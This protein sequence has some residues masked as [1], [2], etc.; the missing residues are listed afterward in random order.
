MK[1]NKGEWSEAYAFVKLI[2]EGEVHASDK[3]LNKIPD[4]LYPILKVYKDEIKRYYENNN[5]KGIIN[6][7][8]YDNNLISSLKS[9]KFISVA[10]DSLELINKSKGSSFEIPIME[11]FLKELGIINFKGSSKKK[12]D[13]KMEIFDN[14][15]EKSDILTFSI[16]SEIGNKP[17]LLNASKLTNFTYKVEGMSDG[18]FNYLNSI[19]KETDKKWI[20]TRF[21]K[22]FD[23]YKNK[24][25]KISLV[26]EKNNIFYQNL[27]LID[28]KL[29]NMLSFILF[30]FYSHE[31]STNIKVLT[32]KLI[33]FNPLNLDDKEKDIFYKK[34][35]SEFIF[36]VTFGMMPNLKWNGDYEIN[37]GLLTVKKDGEILCH[38]I[39]Y[40]KNALNEYLFENT[41]LE[42]PSTTRHKYGQLYKKDNEIFFKLNLQIRIK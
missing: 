27:R 40:D 36:S 6:I 34:K 30:Y 23:E 18:E 9:S 16:K 10:E 14:N 35:I 32:E 26:D 21:K 3:D 22:I 29:P 37:G 1:Y 13:I 31:K 42:T 11:T 25:Y 20:K 38:H 19:T 4:K 33:K 39:F 17:S 2:G 7:I 12:E 24:K 15:L 8:D 41:K 5:K 28:S